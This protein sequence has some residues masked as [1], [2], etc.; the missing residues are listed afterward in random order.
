M[1]L[2]I[3]KQNFQPYRKIFL[4]FYDIKNRVYNTRTSQV[5][6]HPSTTQAR[7]CLNSE[8]RRDPVVSPWYGRRQ[9]CTKL[10]NTY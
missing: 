5:V 7:R 4:S 3:Y 10:L 1:V 6:T 8:I 2:D 9:K